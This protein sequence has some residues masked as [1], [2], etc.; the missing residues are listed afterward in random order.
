MRSHQFPKMPTVADVRGHLQKAEGDAAQVEA[1][2]KWKQALRYINSTSPDYAP[3]EKVPER[4]MAAIRA[5]GGIDWIR[6]C[7]QDQLVWCQKKFIEAY[8]RWQRLEQE[9]FLLPDGPIKDAIHALAD[10]KQKQLTE[11][12]A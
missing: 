11:G 5:A 2:Q 10:T 8:L 4:I 9:Q 3:R 1:E 7:P 6:E 12:K